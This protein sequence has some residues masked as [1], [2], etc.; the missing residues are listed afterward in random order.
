MAMTVITDAP[1]RSLIVN[2]CGPKP[3]LA[4]GSAVVR[5]H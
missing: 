5:K 1:P 2:Y 3:I 4:R